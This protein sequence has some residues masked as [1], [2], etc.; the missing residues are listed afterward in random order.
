MLEWLCGDDKVIVEKIVVE[1]VLQGVFEDLVYCV[2]IGLYWYSLFDIID[3][4]DIVDIDVV[5]VVDIY[6][7]LMD[8]LGIDGL[9]IVVF[10]LF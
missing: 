1:F 5:E 9:L 4:V 8:W 6:F 7:V 3:I 10:Q 2:L